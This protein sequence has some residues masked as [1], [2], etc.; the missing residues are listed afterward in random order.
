MCTQVKTWSKHGALC[1]LHMIYIQILSQ[2]AMGART[3]GLISTSIY[4]PPAP[5][6]PSRGSLATSDTNGPICQSG[7]AWGP[8]SPNVGVR[9]NLAA[10][11]PTRQLNRFS[12]KKGGQRKS[13]H[14]ADDCISHIHLLWSPSSVSQPAGVNN[15]MVTS[16]DDRWCW[17][18]ISSHQSSQ[19]DHHFASPRSCPQILPAAEKGAWGAS[20]WTLCV[21]A[22]LSAKCIYIFMRR[23]HIHTH[24]D[25]PRSQFEVGLGCSVGYLRY[26]GTSGNG[27]YHVIPSNSCT[28]DEWCTLMS[29][30]IQDDL[31]LLLQTNSCFQ[32]PKLGNLHRLKLKDLQWAF[33][34]FL[35]CELTIWSALGTF[36][37]R[38]RMVIQNGLASESWR[39]GTGSSHGDTEMLVIF[40]VKVRNFRLANAAQD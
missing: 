29:H 37:L 12:K 11:T 35:I 2:V 22:Q 4:N 32:W 40:G 19:R 10:T 20:E 38:R 5:K 21:P 13:S 1:I 27:L 16:S 14:D 24:L 9:N 8:T 31:R 3:I 30:R 34:T 25:H 28:G 6:A 36:P 33:V 26:L 7:T 39:Y 17:W 18:S 15:S 23:I